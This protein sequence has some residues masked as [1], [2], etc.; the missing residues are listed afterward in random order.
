MIF[1]FTK[2]EIANLTLT[3]EEKTGD[4]KQAHKWSA[5]IEKSEQEDLYKLFIENKFDTLKNDAR[6][7]IIYDAGSEGISLNAGAGAFYNI[8]YG[9]NSPLSGDNLKRY[10]TIANAIK[11]LR[12]KYESKV[13]KPAES[14]FAVLNLSEETFKILFRNSKP[15]VLSEREIQTAR[16]ILKKAVDE[17]NSANKNYPLEPLEKYRFQFVGLIDSK[18]EKEVWV[19]SFCSDF[20]KDWRAELIMV[21]DGGRCFFNLYVNLTKQTFDRFSVNGEA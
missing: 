16:D 21:E 11:A 3:V 9:P 4:E 8:S 15:A 6:K 7:G 17:Y 13:E 1:A 2:I 12:Y 19:N 18:G 20:E 10:Q 5:K 14:N